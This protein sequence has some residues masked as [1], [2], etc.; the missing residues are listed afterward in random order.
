MASTSSLSGMST[1]PSFKPSSPH[2]CLH[3]PKKLQTNAQLIRFGFAVVLKLIGGLNRNPFPFGFSSVV[4]SLLTTLHFQ[5]FKLEHRDMAELLHGSSNLKC[6]FMSHIY[7]SGPEARL[8]DCPSWLEM[9]DKEEAGL[10]PEFQNLIHLEL[11]YSDYTGD[12]V[13]GHRSL[14]ESLGLFLYVWYALQKH[15]LANNTLGLAFCIQG[16]EMLSLGSFKTGAILL[17]SIYP[18]ADCILCLSICELNILLM[19]WN[20]IVSKLL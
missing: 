8:K 10:I 13:E 15:W 1:K 4:L 14:L 5:S 6:L 16:I 17:A 20:L 19:N 3:C 2:T 12:W 11:G 18:L 7:F 9:E